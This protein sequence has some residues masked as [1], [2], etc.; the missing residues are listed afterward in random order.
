MR[1]FITCTFHTFSCLSVIR[2]NKIKIYLIPNT[3]TGN[4]KE[5]YFFKQFESVVAINVNYTKIKRFQQSTTFD[6]LLI[7]PPNLSYAFPNLVNYPS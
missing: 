4:H 5:H 2:Y 3:A 1:C 6:G 7:L